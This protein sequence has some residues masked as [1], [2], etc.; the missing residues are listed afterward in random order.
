[1]I[2]DSVCLTSEFKR[3]NFELVCWTSWAC[4]CHSLLPLPSVASKLSNFDFCSVNV[5]F[6]LSCS[7]F[8]LISFLLYK[9]IC[10]AVFWIFASNPTKLFSK[11]LVPFPALLKSL[12]RFFISLFILEICLEN[13]P[14]SRA[15]STASFSIVSD[16]CPPHYINSVVSTVSCFT[17]S[18]F[19][20]LYFLCASNW[21]NSFLGVMSQNSSLRCKTVY[22]KYWRYSKSQSSTFLFSIPFLFFYHL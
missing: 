10:L 2:V 9:S 18:S 17:T 20:P 3:F 19:T 8:W 12:S 15:N 4:F 7:C 14:A 5:L 22:H 13:E 11:F 16:I 1:M 6:S 21:A